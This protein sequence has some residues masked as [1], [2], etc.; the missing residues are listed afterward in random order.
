M[1]VSVT[2]ICRGNAPS[3]SG[4]AGSARSMMLPPGVVNLMAFPRRLIRT[5]SIFS[6]SKTA[7]S[8]PSPIRVSTCRPRSSIS[9][10]SWPRTFPIASARRCSPTSRSIR[11]ALFVRLLELPVTAAQ[12]GAGPEQLLLERAAEAHVAHGELDRGE[13][14]ELDRGGTQ[15]DPQLASGAPPEPALQEVD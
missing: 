14:A 6:R 3:P 2:E 5:C 10:L 1:P 7:R 13:L 4:S 15:I 12:F 8:T 9:G 11:P